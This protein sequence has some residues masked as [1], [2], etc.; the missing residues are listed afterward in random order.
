MKWHRLVFALVFLGLV[1][2]CSNPSAPKY[3]SDEEDTG[4]EDDPPTQG[5]LL[6]GSGVYWA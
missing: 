6:E 3:P 4:E 2:S 5:F 1:V